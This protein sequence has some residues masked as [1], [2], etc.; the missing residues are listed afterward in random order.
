M[1][2]RHLRYFIAVAEELHFGRAAA[3]LHISQQPLSRQIR[4]LEN[5]LKVQLFDRTKR[6]IRLTEAG[7]I[8]LTEAKKTLQ[9]AERAVLLAQRV[10][11]GEIGQLTVGFTGLA[12]NSLLLESV[13]Q[14]R[15][16]YPEVDLTLDELRTIEQVE[17]LNANRLHL[18][19]LHPPIDDDSL[20][21][22]TIY[23]EKL[24]AAL[25]ETHPL[26]REVPQP[27][28]LKE[29]ADESF[30]LFPRK[31][32]PQLYDRIISFCQQAGF[33]PKVVQETIPQQ[34][35]LG[36]VSIGVGVALMPASVQNLGRFGVVF[37][38]L[39]EPA[40]ELE[41][42]VAWHPNTTHPVLPS[43]VGIMREVALMRS[44]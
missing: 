38:E 40:P 20:I 23:R 3:R 29:L 26:A 8:F 31:I 37:R 22:E 10:S 30:I 36:L 11:R 6:T 16:R 17:A 42:A 13:R 18:G 1:E 28:S 4:D 15:E 43:F 24:V 2:L 19:L 25:P 7:K 39:V 14:F 34:T 27:I 41:L 9:Q 44:D 35:I 21:L 33:S 5:E 12:L 32:G